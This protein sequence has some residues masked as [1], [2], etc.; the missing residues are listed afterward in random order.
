MSGSKEDFEASMNVDA[1][2][3]LTCDTS[4]LDHRSPVI[5]EENTD[6]DKFENVDNVPKDTDLNIMG[7][8]SS[9]MCSVE[10]SRLLQSN[11]FP[12]ASSL[13]NLQE[14]QLLEC[15][16]CG[17]KFSAKDVGVSKI[18]LLCG[19]H[20]AKVMQC[21]PV[22]GDFPGITT[23]LSKQSYNNDDSGDS[24]H[25]E[26]DEATL[27][28]VPAYDESIDGSLKDQIEVME[29]HSKIFA[30]EASEDYKETQRLFVIDKLYC[31]PLTGKDLGE[32][33][34]SIKKK[35]TRF[36]TTTSLFL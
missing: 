26:D 6:L 8:I 11:D 34:Y 30:S 17:E 23:K 22:G 3:E 4:G 31:G 33:L 20:H 16:E 28:H 35:T 25:S 13:S 24:Y 7:P 15:C 9:D 18:L 19:V 14:A 27:C 29:D 1:L 12:T 2:R 32:V 5:E 10:G 21:L 36:D